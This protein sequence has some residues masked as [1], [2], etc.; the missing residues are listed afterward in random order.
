MTS[1]GATERFDSWSL[2]LD[3]ALPITAS[4]RLLSELWTGCSLAPYLGGIGQGV[5]LAMHTGIRSRGGWFAVN[6]VPGQGKTRFAFGM[7]VDDVDGEDVG[8]GARTRNRS[9]FGNVIYAF[10]RHID[11]GVEISGWRTEYEGRG[12]AEAWRSQTSFFYRF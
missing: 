10:N 3:L 11:V 1:T 12:D 9:L 5:D 7:S 4:V 8:A 2:N 6:V